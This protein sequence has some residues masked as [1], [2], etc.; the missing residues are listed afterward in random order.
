MPRDLALKLDERLDPAP[1]RAR[2]PGVERLLRLVRVSLAED[3]PKL[4]L[5]GVG[6]GKRAVLRLDELELCPLPGREVLGVLPDG[7][8]R[9]LDLLRGDLCLRQL[10]PE[11]G[12][13]LLVLLLADPRLDPLHLVEGPPPRLAPHLVESRVRPLDDVERVDAP[14]GV[15]AMLHDA[16]RDPPRAVAGDDLD[17][18]ALFPRQ[19]LEEDVEHLLAVAL[20]RPHDRVR[21]VV[22]DDRDVA[23]A[24]AVAGL[25]DADQFQPLVAFLRVGLKHLPRELDEPTDCLP[26]DAQQ[27]GDALLAESALDEPRR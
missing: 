9:V 23:V 24:L 17:G 18:L 16:V 15:R 25:V 4:L 12:L 1:L 5:H 14:L 22:D 26:V 21:L 11:L 13:A 3:N 19:L 8:P 7:I 27:L 10:V 2:D 20:V 6:S